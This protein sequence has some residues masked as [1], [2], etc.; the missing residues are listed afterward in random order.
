M[1]RVRIRLGEPPAVVNLG[2]GVHG[3]TSRCDVFQLPDLWQLHLYGYT[4]ELTVGGTTHPIR[5][6]HVSLIPPGES[7][8]YRYGGRSEHLYV[9]LRLAAAGEEHTL[10]VMQDAGAETPLLTQLLRQAIAP[11][12]AVM[13]SAQVWTVLWRL[14]HLARAEGPHA[15]VAD[16]I[17]YVESNLAVPLTVPEIAAAAG[18][19]PT[20]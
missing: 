14:T 20:T 11:G 19:H 7:V 16:A 4:A 5:P 2:I 17:A 10:P 9:H 13:A 3:V 6:G 1:D 12:S 8:T 15:A 18:S